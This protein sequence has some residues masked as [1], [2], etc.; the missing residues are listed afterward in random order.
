MDKYAIILSGGTGLRLGSEIPKQY[1][2]VNNRRII[3]YVL[4]TISLC[5]FDGI[6]VVADSAWQDEIMESWMSIC[7]GLTGE[8]CG[9]NCRPKEGVTFMFAQPGENRQLSIYNG[10]LKLKEHGA[11]ADAAVLV[12]DAARPTTS[13]GQ[14]LECISALS[15]GNYDGIVPVLPMKDTVYLSADGKQISSLI[16]RSTVYAGQAPEAFVFEKYLR[17]NE[18]LLPEAIKQIN[19]STEPAVKAG[20]RMKMIPGDESNYKITTQADLELFIKQMEG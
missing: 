14:I 20:M 15:E 18:A 5:G 10:L 17:A 12:Q 13:G 2:K 16:D 1:L 6:V 8:A 3:D 4:G 11:K 19:G 9:V 7:R